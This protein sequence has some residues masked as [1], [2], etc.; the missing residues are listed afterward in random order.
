MYKTQSPTGIGSSN[1][2]FI[3]NVYSHNFEVSGYNSNGL[4]ILKNYC[5]NYVVKQKTFTQ[6]RVNWEIS[7]VFAAA[8]KNRTYFRFHFN[9]LDDFLSYLNS[10]NYPNHSIAITRHEPP[11]G[12]V[13]NF[14]V[15]STKTPRDY[16][17]TPIKYVAN[18]LTEIMSKFKL[19]VLQTGKGKT[20]IALSGMGQYNKRVL[21]ICKPMYIE[22]WIADFTDYFDLKTKDIMVVRGG[23]NLKVLIEL[24]K[25]NKLEAKII[26]VS[27]RTYYDY[28]ED[29]ERFNGNGMFDVHPNDFCKLLKIGYRLIDEVHQDF[30]LNYRCDLYTNVE[31]DISLSATM[32]PDAP[33]LKTMYEIMFPSGNRFKGIP[34]DKY[35]NVKSIFYSASDPKKLKCKRFGLGFY[36]QT[37][38]EDS[39]L[40]DRVILENYLGMISAIVKKEF[41]DTY[42]DGKKFIVF[43]GTIAMATAI[44]KRLNKDY[45]QYNIKRYVGEDDYETCLLEPVGRVSTL[46]SAGTAVDIDD[47]L[48]TLMTDAHDS[49]Q[50]NEQVLGRTR[51]SKGKFAH[52]TPV[53]A[54]LSCQQ[55][56]SHVKYDEKKHKVFAGKVLSHTSAISQFRI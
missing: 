32:D 21:E 47:L 7:T 5:R 43:A 40:G 50:G 3:I 56:Q 55:I 48:F 2:S 11:I 16:Q 25:Q 17:L 51:K 45:P 44:T 24:A 20:F 9:Q 34:Y 29:W 8:N 4:D 13:V 14:K 26:I 15:K 36:S 42:E 54:Y 33:I 18:L 38:F 1:A 37:M 46:K 41:F 28:L 6:G 52:L 23:K 19:V 49:T 10:Q 22:K 30:H 39:I 35:I 53:F 27:N 12:E 31:S